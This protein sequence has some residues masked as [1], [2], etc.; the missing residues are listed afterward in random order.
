MDGWDAVRRKTIEKAD[1]FGGVL[2]VL[3]L[4]L[5]LIS[6]WDGWVGFCAKLGCKQLIKHI[7]IYDFSRSS[8]TYHPYELQYGMDGWDFVRSLNENSLSNIEKDGFFSQ[9]LHLWVAL[10][11]GR[12]GFNSKLG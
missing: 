9:F 12:V 6:V 4:L 2:T 7:K 1:L 11:K 5:L 8:C 10:W 3:T